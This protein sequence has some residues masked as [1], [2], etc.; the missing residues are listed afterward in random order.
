MGVKNWG[1]VAWLALVGCGGMPEE[2]QARQVEAQAC[3][4]GVASRVKVVIPPLASTA[5]RL[6]GLTDVQ[7]T[8]YFATNGPSSEGSIL[9]RSN[10][11]AAGTVPVRGF[12]VGY[13]G[14]ES[15]VAVG[16]RLFFQMSVAITGTELWVS[17]GT[18]LGTKL[19]RDITSGP[20][21]ST[22]LSATAV[23]G[24]LVFFRAR[25]GTEDAELWRS[26]G[27]AVGTQRIS[28]LGGVNGLYSQATLQVGGALLFFRNEDSGTRLWRTDGTL[29]GT[30]AVAGLS[31]RRLNIVQVA[32]AGSLGLFIVED[33]PNSQVWKTDGTGGGTVKLETFGRAVH[34]LGVL[35]SK[36]YLSSVDLDTQQ[37]RIQSLLLAG[38]G[39]ASVAT[40][41]RYNANAYPFVQRSTLSAGSLYFS[42][43]QFV[44]GPAPAAVELWATD[45]TSAGTRK[46]FQTLSR[47]DEYASP[48]FATGEGVVLFS[49][50][51]TGS[52]LQ[53]WFTRGTVATTGRF[54]T[55]GPGT[56][57]IAPDGFTRLGSRVYFRALDD[58][59]REQLWSVPASF[60]CPAGF[61]DARE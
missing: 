3:P 26:D 28:V 8:L 22:L 17:D 16:N 55:T 20:E 12:P 49:G 11:T 54:A 43:A 42:V 30:Q 37:L 61:N 1:A 50:S 5:T 44:D 14:V 18:S 31:S 52:G 58:T 25:S 39:K 21:G 51:A 59:D 47:N 38:G 57:A 48:V 19:V 46:L 34:I 2:E 41:P 35:G 9:W 10:G 45:G 7:G 36:V 53:P 29:A 24:R 23:N 4:S 27:T 56:P 60:S 15:P 40:L 6:Q 13:S 33:G 32:Q